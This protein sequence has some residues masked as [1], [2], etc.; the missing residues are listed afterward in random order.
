MNP[1]TL[2]VYSG[3]TAIG[4]LT[5]AHTGAYGWVYNCYPGYGN[6]FGVYS[7]GGG[8][9]YVNFVLFAPH[10]TVR[11]ATMGNG[12]KI[13]TA[14]YNQAVPLVM[15]PSGA[16]YRCLVS[17]STQLGSLPPAPSEDVSG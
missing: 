9:E 13:E 16:T 7:N 1:C 5:L 14:R 11:L 3:S 10:S 17:S 8:A 15:Y 12:F 6:P 2:V 4:Y